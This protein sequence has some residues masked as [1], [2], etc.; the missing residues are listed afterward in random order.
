VAEKVRKAKQKRLKGQQIKK[1]IDTFKR[2]I[3]ELF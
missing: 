1:V 2:T 3:K